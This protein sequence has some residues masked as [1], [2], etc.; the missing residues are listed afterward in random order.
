[1]AGDDEY[2]AS[3]E[4]APW[5]VVSQILAYDQ[6]VLWRQIVHCVYNRLCLQPCHA[7]N[8]PTIVT[9]DQPLY[10]KAAEI[11]IGAPQSSHL[12]GIVLMLGC[13]HTLMNVMGAIGTLMQGT[14]LKNI[15]ETVY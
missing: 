10:W 13:F 6:Y 7:A 8:L 3:G 12:K 11:L 14:G 2:L 1:M 5:A 4:P 15:L 9:F